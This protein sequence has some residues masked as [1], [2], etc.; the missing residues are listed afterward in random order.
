MM[1]FPHSFVVLTAILARANGSI[2]PP[3]ANEDAP[4]C[5]GLTI[6]FTRLQSVHTSDINTVTRSLGGRTY[7]INNIMPV[8]QSGTGECLKRRHRFQETKNGVPVF[9]ASLIVT[10]NGCENDYHTAFGDYEPSPLSDIPMNAIADLDGKTFSVIEEVTG[11]YEPTVTEDA[12]LETLINFFATPRDK[13][14]DLKLTI[15]PSYERGDLLAHR[16]EV[17][18]SHHGDQQLYDVFIS[19]VTGEIFSICQKV[20]R[21]RQGRLARRLRKRELADTGSTFDASGTKSEMC[22][23]CASQDLVTWTTTEVECSINSLYLNDEGRTTTCLEGTTSAGEQVV[24]PGIVSSLNYFGTYDCNQGESGCNA[25]GLPTNCADALSDVH[26][27]VTETMKFMQ[28]Y[29]GVMGGLNVDAGDPIKTA[30]FVHFSNAYCN[31]FFTTQTNSLYFGDCD[32]QFWTPLT[33]LD[34]SAHELAHGITNYASGLVYAYQP[35]GL[36]EGYSDIIGAT[37]EFVL[38]DSEDVADFTLG[39]NLIGEGLDGFI[40][41]YMENPARDGKSIDN[42][43]NFNNDMNVHYTSGVPNLAFTSSVRACEAN[44]CGDTRGCVMMMG[45]LYMYA[46]IHGLTELSGYLDA[47]SATCILT[48]EYMARGMATTSCTEAQAV[49]FV[50][51]GWARV[52]I[53]VHD[54]CVAT[55]TSGCV[56]PGI[57][58]GGGPIGCLMRVGGTLKNVF[59]ATIGW[60][61]GPLF[62]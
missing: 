55:T 38:N 60:I 5:T 62:D 22:G 32:C 14:G 16:T 39:E 43:C 53:T 2:V 35:G 49:Q 51:D 54:D 20:N 26:Y 30:S 7:G 46:N 37:M 42:V 29:L 18:T 58:S 50:K 6:D 40:L 52:G 27:G 31:A 61:L 8:T 10:V 28:D 59:T 12:T 34:V 19:A 44:G 25:N 15:F 47:A 21:A 24:G 4:Q 41:R 23:S 48:P 1:R 11:T 9:G 33:S 56:L 57:P 17:W 45:P 13:I 36:N 3:L